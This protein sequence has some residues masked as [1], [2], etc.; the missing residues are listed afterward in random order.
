MS[1]DVQQRVRKRW[2]DS[3][4]DVTDPPGYV[5]GVPYLLLMR[6]SIPLFV[7]LRLWA[8]PPRTGISE[9]L[10]TVLVALL[11]AVL[12]TVIT[13][14]PST[15]RSL[16]LLGRSIVITDVIVVSWIYAATQKPESTFFLFYL[17]PL[18]AAAEYLDAKEN[19]IAIGAV[20]AA[21]SLILIKMYPVDL[22]HP[23]NR[24][25]W[26]KVYAARGLFFITA[27]VTVAALI[28]RHR[29][30]QIL[31]RR[32]AGYLKA[33]VT[34]ASRAADH[35]SRSAILS[36][37]LDIAVA[38]SGAL[39]GAI[40]DVHENTPSLAI[41]RKR[42]SCLTDEIIQAAITE[43]QIGHN[44]ASPGSGVHTLNLH[45]THAG[46]HVQITLL[47]VILDNENEITLLTLAFER[48]DALRRDAVGFLEALSQQV[49]QQISHLQLLHNLSITG[50][51]NAARF[52][53]D[54]QIDLALH[55]LTG[56]LKFA[57]AMISLVE[58]NRIHAVRGYNI[59]RAWLRMSDHSLDS[60]DIDAFV[61]RT[62]ET[63]LI[64]G[65]DARF[66][67]PVFDRFDHGT[68]TRIFAPILHD[69]NV[70]GVLEVG[71]LTERASE[72]F[73]PGVEDRVQAVAVELGRSLTVSAT[74]QLASIAGRAMQI[75]RAHSASVHLFD[76][77]DQ[78]RAAG[79]GLANQ[80]FLRT[81]APRQN[82]L[83]ARAIAENR[84][85]TMD[86]PR[87]LAEFHPALHDLG[88]R[89][90]AAFPLS[91]IGPHRGVLYVH[92]W[93]EHHYTEAELQL[94]SIFARQIEIALQ[95]DI[96]LEARRRETERLW[97]LSESQNAM[98]STGPATDINAV[99]KHLATSILNTTDADCVVL[100]QFHN[101]EE[102]FDTPPIMAGDFN[103]T[104]R[105]T[106]AV[107][108]SDL[109]WR[110]IRADGP[111]YFD[112]VQT[113]AEFE[114]D[115]HRF[116]VR[117][118]I[119]G[120]AA[121]P[122]R[123][124]WPAE[125]VGLLFVNYRA[126]RSFDHSEQRLL[127][128][129]AASAAVAIANARLYHTTLEAVARGRSEIDALD[130]IERAIASSIEGLSRSEA[131][132]IFLTEAV[133][134]TGAAVGTI[135]WSEPA[136]N[137]LT[138]VA[139]HGISGPVV[140]KDGEGIVGVA[141]A[142]RRA[143]LVFDVTDAEWSRWYNPI[144]PETRAELA[145]PLLDGG[146]LLGVINLESPIVGRF[147][148]HDKQWIETLAVQLLVFLHSL[149]LNARSLEEAKY[150]IAL[151]MIA[152][153][154]HSV[155]YS[156]DLALRMLL[157]GVTSGAGLGF[158]RAMLFLLDE[159]NDELYG[160]CAV[161]AQTAEEAERQWSAS[162]DTGSGN[163]EELLALALVRAEQYWRTV[164]KD[165]E[166]DCG[167]NRG[168]KAIRV[169]VNAVNALCRSLCENRTVITNYD[170]KDPY[171][172]LLAKMSSGDCGSAFVC[173]PLRT[174]EKIGA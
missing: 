57:F 127:T 9:H 143:K 106:H 95:N 100:Y 145:V 94:G 12:T 35:L 170:E 93:C 70:V 144:I 3:L 6:W 72:V 153:R 33:L 157:T 80:D 79:A 151:A 13:L 137:I 148:D 22:P 134:T 104:G 117:E 18:C 173:L 91:F 44:S 123:S 41:R 60:D 171:R 8:D 98:Q 102:R 128:A 96:L 59:P 83:G 40:W 64:S 140:V 17:L 97:G 56:Q 45:V 75:L 118:G 16:E 149:D 53:Q 124:I 167:L 2:A 112:D 67:T 125:P 66:A 23:S 74:D 37:A 101:G 156:F 135:M 84:I 160:Y 51:D 99:L 14:G 76:G 107:E 29:Y 62:R 146:K 52:T 73:V 26:V 77:A 174:S 147:T 71:T 43:G 85:L 162:P 11:S 164:E 108:P 5:G 69:Q 21:F 172:D 65:F 121:I 39:E 116:H 139:S 133:R 154:I 166:R 136:N 120:M 105:M 15:H 36:D 129:I 114:T 150:R 30:Q 119:H 32:R 158:S 38:H 86:E 58:D 132:R 103:Q 7:S 90:I 34:F 19:A 138:T 110:F 48:N 42:H 78:I 82:G 168:V 126:Q 31:L 159:T 89:A 155:E 24:V 109:A 169:H 111:S 28:R 55:T 25:L 50:R 68:L 88:V 63:L 47:A 163:V 61:V 141:A 130:R 27:G 92:F 165:V 115:P 161:G 122:L 46:H 131:F 54:L 4:F 81:Y 20:I 142:Q 152:R 10:A 1:L 113:T 87:Q 49:V